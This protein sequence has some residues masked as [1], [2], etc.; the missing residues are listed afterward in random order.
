MLPA[1]LQGLTVGLLV[2]LL[3]IFK[4]NNSKALYRTL[5]VLGTVCVGELILT[6]VNT[7]S[8]YLDGFLVGYPVKALHLIVL[9]R[10][11]NCAAR[12]AVSCILVYL[13]LPPVQKLFTMRKN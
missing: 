13:L 1:I 2:R 11:L 10:L 12:T 6:A 4:K 5:A 9:P 3:P 8:L 7:A